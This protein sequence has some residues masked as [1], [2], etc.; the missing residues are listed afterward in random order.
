MAWFPKLRYLPYLYSADWVTF[1]ARGWDR[2]LAGLKAVPGLRY[3]EVGAFEGR[4][5]NWFLDHI[6]THASSAATLVEPFL[7]SPRWALEWNLRMAGHSSRAR[8]LQGRSTELLPGLAAQQFDIV[9]VD[10]SHRAADV[11]A[12]AREAWRLL[13]PGG[14]LIFDDYLWGKG[15]KQPGERPQPAIDEF[16]GSHAQ[17]CELLAKGW[18]VIVR[19]RPAGGPQDQRTDAGHAPP[20]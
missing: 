4:S 5:A 2:V 7:Y 1:N 6:L 13:K 14:V 8:V 20:L 3:L 10:G 9:Y 19:K 15:E 18:Q 12:D 17:A 11:A 16:L